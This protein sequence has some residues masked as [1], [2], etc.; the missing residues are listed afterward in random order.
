L[1][2]GR[3]DGE[4]EEDCSRVYYGGR[5]ERG[6]TLRAIWVVSDEQRP[7]KKI[8]EVEMDVDMIVVRV[9]RS[10]GLCF[11]GWTS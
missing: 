4:R 8:V 9:Y 6:V 1:W 3:T 5:C 2:T 11:R 10:G 7:R